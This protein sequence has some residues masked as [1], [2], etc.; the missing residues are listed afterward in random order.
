[1]TEQHRPFVVENAAQ[2]PLGRVVVAAHHLDPGDRVELVRAELVAAAVADLVHV[3]DQFLGAGLVL[4]LEGRVGH[5]VQDVHRHVVVAD[6]RGDGERLA[7]P[8]VALRGGAA[9][10]QRHGQRHQMPGTDVLRLV[11]GE[12]RTRSHHDGSGTGHRP[13][14]I[15]RPIRVPIGE[16]HPGRQPLVPAL[17]QGG[18]G[19]AQHRRRSHPDVLDAVL[20]SDARQLVE[21]RHGGGAAH[22][23]SVRATTPL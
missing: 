9:H 11:V 6:L 2:N 18:A 10:V 22:R 21:G 19:P 20:P 12:V 7:E 8:A 17:V 13:R 4:V 15:R 23:A 16:A 5:V 1:V 3:P 14:R